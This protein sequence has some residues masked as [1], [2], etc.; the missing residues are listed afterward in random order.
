MASTN[1]SPPTADSVRQEGNTLINT[2]HLLLGSKLR[3]TMTDGRIVHG[4][5]LCLDRLGNI[6]LDNAVE[7]REMAYNIPPP[8]VTIASE[9][10]GNRNS[11]DDN[12]DD[13]PLCNNNQT[14]F[15]WNTERSLSQAVI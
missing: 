12:S 6:I 1:G 2:I 14:A 3:I 15:K 10:R 4:R 5:F 13:R 7:F 11:R 9:D 8:S